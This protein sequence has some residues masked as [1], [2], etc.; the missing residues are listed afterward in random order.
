MLLLQVYPGLVEEHTFLVGNTIEQLVLAPFCIDYEL[1]LEREV[2]A[3][4]LLV[5]I[6]NDTP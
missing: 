6:L 4:Q 2:A 5:A 3:M 1:C